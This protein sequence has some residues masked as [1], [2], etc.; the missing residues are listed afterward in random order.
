MLPSASSKLPCAI[1]CCRVGLYFLLEDP[2]IICQIF[3]M[4]L[5]VLK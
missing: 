3:N 1:A 4:D 2:L 5:E